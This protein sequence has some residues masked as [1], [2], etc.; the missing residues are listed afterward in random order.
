MRKIPKSH[1]ALLLG[2]AAVFTWSGYRPYDRLTWW[3][4]I[5]PGLIGLIVL[6]ATYS[7]FRFTTLVYT[8]I[9]LHTSILSVRRHYTYAREQAFSW[10]SDTLHCQLDLYDP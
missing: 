3:L 4:E 2:V 10:L 6:A 7:R 9:A 1:I 5:F 8:L